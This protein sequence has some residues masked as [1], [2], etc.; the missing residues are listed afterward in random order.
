MRTK[1]IKD[2]RLKRTYLQGLYDGDRSNPL[3]LSYD[4]IQRFNGLRDVCRMLTLRKDHALTSYS[5]IYFY[6]ST[7]L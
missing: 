2:P 6:L 1:E 7:Y 3:N 4:A 5:A